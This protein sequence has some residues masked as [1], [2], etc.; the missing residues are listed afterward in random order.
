[1]TAFAGFGKKLKTFVF[2]N[3]ATLI[4]ILFVLTGLCVS[5][6]L[7]LESFM[8]ELLAR[9][10]RNGLLVLSLIIPITAGLG[11]N[12]GIVVGALAGMLS[13]I[14]TRYLAQLDTLAHL[15]W[16]GG[17][18]GIMFS[19]LLALP[20]AAL[21]GLLTGKLYNKTRGQEMIASLI[22]CYFATGLY[23]FIVLYAIGGIIPVP[24]LHRMIKPDGIGILASF[25]MGPHP[26]SRLFDPETGKPGL[27]YALDWIWRAPFPTV[28]VTITLCMLGFIMIRRMRAKNDSAL[29]ALIHVH[30]DNANCMICIVLLVLGLHGAFFPDGIGFI[31]VSPIKNI[32]KIPVVTGSVI[33]AVCLFI[34]YFSGTKLGQDCRSIGRSRHIAEVS[35]IDVD[36]TRIIATMISMVLASWGM[37]IFLQNTGSVSTY[38][39][40]EQVGMSSVAALLAGGATTSKASVKNALIGLFLFHSMYI[41]S[42]YIGRLF[43]GSE[44][45]GEFMRLFMQ[46]GVIVLALVLH[47]W[48]GRKAVG[49]I[50]SVRKAG[51]TILTSDS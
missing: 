24:A 32:G 41:V 4:F 38:T 31:P 12:F 5:A 15:T 35:G 25:D 50:E 48:K 1:M 34:H 19:F 20:L 44:G 46:Y 43:S 39:S 6:N 2:D 29:S 9:F 26:A 10:F 8:N 42:P 51:T 27:S 37:I 3:I 30:H 47:I 16:F 36:R 40:Q 49:N 14:T 23:Q 33:L 45:I 11:F 21:F 17:F 13:L 28:L 7:S 22:V 18:S